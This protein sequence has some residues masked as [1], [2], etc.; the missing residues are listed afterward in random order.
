MIGGIILLAMAAYFWFVI[1]QDESE[2]ASRGLVKIIKGLFGVK[3]YQIIA[4]VFA[5][6][7]LAAAI[8]E[9]YKYFTT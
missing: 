7:M 4:K 9:F 3:A 8:S 5:V 1:A 2:D 6:F